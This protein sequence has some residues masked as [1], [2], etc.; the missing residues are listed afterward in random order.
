MTGKEMRAHVLQ[1]VS[2]LKGK[3]F[4]NRDTG[5]TIEIIRDSA[6]K[7]AMGSTMYTEKALM[8]DKLPTIL[9]EMK[10]N[11]WGNRKHTDKKTVLGY[12]N[13][14]Y[15]SK[16]NNKVK[17]IRIAVQIRTNGKFYYNLHV[18]LK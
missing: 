9:V 2:S 15:K 10:K 16:I 12:L 5:I 18:N 3:K 8:I 4:I 11:N 7:S 1:K 17:L 6:N 13:F 14:K